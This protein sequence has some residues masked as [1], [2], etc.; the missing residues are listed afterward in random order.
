[1]CINGI[2]EKV[3]V[4][5]QISGKYQEVLQRSLPTSKIPFEDLCKNFPRTS[6]RVVRL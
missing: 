3:A 6:T 1:M 2:I 4:E 5:G